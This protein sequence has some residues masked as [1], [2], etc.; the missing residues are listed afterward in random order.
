[1]VIFWEKQKKDYICG[2]ILHENENMN[3][4][5]FNEDK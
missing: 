2:V 5:D 4:F 3:D 1:M